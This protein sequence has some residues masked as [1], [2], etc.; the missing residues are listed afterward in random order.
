MKTS[1]EEG[2]QVGLQIQDSRKL[3]I[4][5]QDWT[6]QDFKTSRLQHQEFKFS[7]LAFFA[8]F[9]CFKQF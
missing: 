1:L 6:A 4:L 5:N 9:K 7:R 2:K 8:I 3:E